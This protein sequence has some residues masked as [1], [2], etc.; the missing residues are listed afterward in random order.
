MSLL[1]QHLAPIQI[2]QH[3]NN[4]YQS[5]RLNLMI[6]QHPVNQQIQHHHVAN[7]N[8]HE[9]KIFSVMHFHLIFLGIMHLLIV[10]Y[11]VK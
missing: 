7:Y 1:I 8:V 10:L 2:R 11:S 6:H 5:N 9:A 3:L 4:D